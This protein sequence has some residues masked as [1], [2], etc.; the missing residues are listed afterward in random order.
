MVLFFVFFFTLYSSLCSSE[1]T[2]L[3]RFMVQSTI[4]QVNQH[5][6]E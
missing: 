4:N 5:Q 1:N 6:Q 2:S 3:L